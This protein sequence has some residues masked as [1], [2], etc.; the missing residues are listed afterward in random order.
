MQVEKE[1]FPLVGYT[2]VPQRARYKKHFETPEARVELL[3]KVGTRMSYEYG[4]R[5]VFLDEV[6]IT[7]RKK[8]EYKTEYQIVADKTI[9]EEQIEESLQ[10]NI[11]YMLASKV[12]FWFD[13]TSL[14]FRGGQV[15]VILDG[16]YQEGKDVSFILKN[17]SLA[18][19]EPVSYTHLTLPT[20]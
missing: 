10:P 5:Q 13:G 12:G 15:Q 8:M 1:R 6:T 17:L 3:A 18:D 7:A 9:T 14:M 20:N 2:L 19:I 11:G 16:G 4:I